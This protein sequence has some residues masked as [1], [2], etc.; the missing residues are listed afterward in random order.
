MDASSLVKAYLGAM[1][2]RDLVLAGSMLAPG[3]SMQF[4]G[5]VT[6][7]SLG[8]LIEWAKPRYRFV[9]KTYERFDQ[10]C[11]RSRKI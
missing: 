6:F 1:E 11:H 4:P 9:R 2:S 3:F 8:E 10:C 7:T 5:P